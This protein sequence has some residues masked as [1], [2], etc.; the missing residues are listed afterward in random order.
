M[1]Y[2]NHITANRRKQCSDKYDELIK[3]ITTKDN[4]WSLAYEHI[5]ELEYQLEQ[6]KKQI[7]EYQNFFTLM[8]KLL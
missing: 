4:E 5:L 2:Y 7:E 6:Q 8:K 3:Y 1:A